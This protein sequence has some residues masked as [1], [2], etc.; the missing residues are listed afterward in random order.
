MAMGKTPSSVHRR[1]DLLPDNFLA[2]GANLGDYAVIN[3]SIASF[4]HSFIV[5]IYIYIISYIYIYIS[6][7][8]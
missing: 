3:G 6:G 8:Y 1:S 4:I 2:C 7:Y 5:Y